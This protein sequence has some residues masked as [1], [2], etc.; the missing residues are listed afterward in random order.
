MPNNSGLLEGPSNTGPD[1]P[2]FPFGSVTGYHQNGN[3]LVDYFDYVDF[4]LLNANFHLLV[5]VGGIL[6]F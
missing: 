2:C 5:E 1:Q 3:T 4:L 6:I